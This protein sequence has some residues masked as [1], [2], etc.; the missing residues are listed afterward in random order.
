MRHSYLSQ[1]SEPAVQSE[2]PVANVYLNKIKI[3]VDAYRSFSSFYAGGQTVCTT[4][5]LLVFMKALVENRLV[6]KETL[7]AMQQWHTMWPGMEYGYGL[8]RMRFIPFT[9]KYMAWGHLG[10]SGAFMLYFPNLDTYAA[11]S[12]NQ[13]AYQSKG[14]NF[15]FFNVSTFAA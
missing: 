10:A 6:K 9:Q 8:M 1:Y 13:T 3:N 7:N 4:E 2:Y 11:G 14:M 15:L 5:D 12:F